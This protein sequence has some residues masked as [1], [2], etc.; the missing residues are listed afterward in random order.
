[1]SKLIRIKNTSNEVFDRIRVYYD[2]GYSASI[3]IEDNDFT[4]TRLDRS[5]QEVSI[6]N[7]A[8]ELVYDTPITN[9]VIKYSDDEHVL[10][11]LNDI[12]ELEER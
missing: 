10:E 7:N 11:I 1:M 3:I 6:L 8:G 4:G 9:D 2:N 5:M 12:S